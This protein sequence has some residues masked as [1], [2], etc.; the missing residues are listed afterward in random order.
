MTTDA[1]RYL[2]KQSYV[3]ITAHLLDEDLV[4]R[5]F[6]LDTSE[7]KVRH[8]SENLLA[9][10]QNVI[11]EYQ[12]ETSVNDITINFNDTNNNDIHDTDEVDD[13]IDFLRQLN[14]YNDDDDQCDN[15]NTQDSDTTQMSQTQSQLTEMSDNYEMREMSQYSQELE[16][17]ELEM[18]TDVG[19]TYGTGRNPILSRGSR[20]SG[21]LPSVDQQPEAPELTQ[22]QRREITMVSDNA[23][24]I[25]K[26]LRVLGKYQW[27]GCAGH[28]LNLVV[29]QGFK[30]VFA[31]AKLLNKCK[32]IVKQINMS[33]P[34]LYDVKKYQEELDIGQ[35]ALLQE[36]VTR[37]WSILKMME[38]ILKNKDAVTLALRDADK[39]EIMLNGEEVL[40]VKEL[41]A[42]LNLF[43]IAGEHLG[44]EKEVTISLIVPMFNFLRTKVLKDNA[45]DSNMLKNM[46]HHMRNK[47]NN[48]YTDM[49]V[50]FLTTVAFL[51]PRSKSKVSVC[52][53]HLRSTVKRICEA[54]ESDYIPATEGQEQDTIHNFT[55][56]GS[57]SSRSSENRPR[58][59]VTAEQQVLRGLFP[60]DE[61]YEFHNDSTPLEGKIEEEINI[62]TALRFTENEKLKLNVLEWWKHSKL[63]FP[64][65]Y[66][67]ARALLH[68]PATSV[69]SERIFSEA[70][71]I[72]RARRSRFLPVNLNR[73]LFIKKNMM[74]VPDGVGNFNEEAARVALLGDKDNITPE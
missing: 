14:Y 48:R 63:Q 59:A 15:L 66:Q 42:L 45:N 57:A 29:K 6:V 35:G 34:L 24:D 23:A 56:P 18:L 53:G 21:Q 28:H 55:A 27:F 12:L 32:V 74:Y 22:R 20:S 52:N 49:Q 64:C 58:P 11:R 44:K 38:S 2:S 8:T 25:S 30:K 10:V 62:Y 60:D 50:T 5:N 4:L 26:A 7:I 73:H 13:G 3:T 17:P 1:R 36:V 39:M 61:D 51:D 41:I 67:A 72:A 69:P 16:P 68:T 70:G 46:K 43:K 47:L 40:K 9:H 54:Y 65:L 71:Y 33:L 31:A 37:W 19:P